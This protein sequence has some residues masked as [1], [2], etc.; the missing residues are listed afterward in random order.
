MFDL[1]AKK[2]STGMP[3]STSSRIVQNAARCLFAP[4]GKKSLN[5]IEGI[6]GLSFGRYELFRS[7]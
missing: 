2:K 7:Y 6:E 4:A 3:W 1:G 5:V